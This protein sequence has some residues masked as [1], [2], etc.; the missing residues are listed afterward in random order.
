ML[1]RAACRL[2]FQ[3]ENKAK[4]MGDAWL[5][6]DGNSREQI[7]LG[8]RLALFRLH[9]FYSPSGQLLQTL[10][11][12]VPE[13]RRTTSQVIA[14]VAK[15]ELPG[16]LWPTLVDFL[17]KAC[18][19]SPDDNAKQA[20]LEALGY[21]CEE[22]VRLISPQSLRPFAA[23]N[24]DTHTRPAVLRQQIMVLFSSSDSRSDRSQHVFRLLELVLTHSLS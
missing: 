15:I 10:G 12:P 13:A 16:N 23:L 19:E 18:L 17:L 11:S 7:K 4:M 2:W 6:I 3:D 8:V 14:K 21:V 9:F 1:L 22:V 20:A 24:D 5:A